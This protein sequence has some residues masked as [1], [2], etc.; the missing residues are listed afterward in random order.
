[1]R[2]RGKEAVIMPAGPGA[3]IPFLYRARWCHSH[4]ELEQILVTSDKELGP[5]PP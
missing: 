3:A 4:D 2:A 5:P 1:M